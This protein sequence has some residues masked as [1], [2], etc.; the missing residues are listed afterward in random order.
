MVSA[1]ESDSLLW[2]S[3]FEGSDC[4]GEFDG[5]VNGCERVLYRDQ[6][7]PASDACVATV[8]NEENTT[9]DAHD[10]GNEENMTCGAHDEENETVTCDAQENEVILVSVIGTC[11]VLWEIVNADYQ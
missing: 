3:N 8:E 11:D 9:C 4:H 6:I 10:E 2:E 5:L 1:E 7:L